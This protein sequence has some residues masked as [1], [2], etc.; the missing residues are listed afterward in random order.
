MLSLY[1]PV[2]GLLLEHKSHDLVNVLSEFRL[3]SH[4]CC[5]SCSSLVILIALSE[6]VDRQA[7]ETTGTWWCPNS[8]AARTLE[9]GAYPSIV[10]IC[11]FEFRKFP[12]VTCMN[13]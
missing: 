9:Q 10:V 4:A 7:L 11:G 8:G 2:C 6:D 12:L 1:E 5:H 3:Q 13:A